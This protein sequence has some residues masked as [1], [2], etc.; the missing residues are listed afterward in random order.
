MGTGSCEQ[1]PIESVTIDE[2]PQFVD[3]SDD[4]KCDGQE[5]DFGTIQVSEDM[6]ISKLWKTTPCC[7]RT[8]FSLCE[9]LK[10]VLP[11]AFGYPPLRCRG[12]RLAGLG[13]LSD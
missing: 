2:S 9:T 7:V 12:M 3:E 5:I 13:W 11:T 6:P 8:W 4:D 1:S 10:K